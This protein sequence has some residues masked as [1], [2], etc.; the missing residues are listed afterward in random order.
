MLVERIRGAVASAR[1]PPDRVLVITDSLRFSELR[2]LG[3]G[4]ELLSMPAGRPAAGDLE[5]MRRRVR[6]LIADR[7]PLRA[8]SLGSLGP[9][10]LGLSE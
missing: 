7:R 4:F 9:E 2:R 8:V 1:V 3:V 6:L 5:R 10:L